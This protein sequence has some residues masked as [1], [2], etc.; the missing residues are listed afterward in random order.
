MAIKKNFY[1]HDNYIDNMNEN[2]YKKIK[3]ALNEYINNYEYNQNIN[4]SG[5]K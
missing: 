1:P 5:T 3:L 2:G 4:K